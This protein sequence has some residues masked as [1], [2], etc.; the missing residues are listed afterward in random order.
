[1]HIWVSVCVD[2]CMLNLIGADGQV[3]SGVT[4][5]DCA[6]KDPVCKDVFLLTFFVSHHFISVS[7]LVYNPF[8]LSHLLLFY[9]VSL[10][11]FSLV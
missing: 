2:L 7:V 3:D 9:L 6:H 1:M 5:D 8:D 11:P 10:S 4:V